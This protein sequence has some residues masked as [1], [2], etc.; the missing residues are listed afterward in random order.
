MFSNLL[1]KFILVFTPSIVTN[2]AN[3]SVID[4]KIY[5]YFYSNKSTRARKDFSFDKGGKFNKNP[6]QKHAEFMENL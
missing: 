2:Q 5:I 3:K 6:K 4:L 1:L